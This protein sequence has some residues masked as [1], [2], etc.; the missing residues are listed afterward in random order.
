MNF[1]LNALV[2]KFSIISFATL[3]SGCAMPLP[4]QIASWAL[5][6]ISYVA[7]EKSVTDHGISIVARKD[8]ALLRVVQGNEICSANDS[9][10]IA[11]AETGNA[12]TADETTILSVGRGKTTPVA[13]PENKISSQLPGIPKPNYGNIQSKIAKNQRF[14]FLGSRVWSDRLD[15]DMYY[16]VGSFSNRD[17]AQSLINKHS[18]LGP[19]VLVSLL[20]GN[21]VYR[22]AVG[23]FKSFQRGDVKLSIKK[24]GI[25]NAWAMQIDHQK[26]K[27]SSSKEFF[28]TGKPVALVPEIMK[29]IKIRPSQKQTIDGGVAEIPI[30][31]NKLG[32][33][34][35]PSIGNQF[36]KT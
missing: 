10:S 23:P 2:F 26:W 36:T 8:C 3:L 12:D 21:K 33:N 15:A 7:T 14:L 19:A 5:D 13:V 25:I 24:S 1:R 28:N 18:D 31:K 35:G 30:L 32:M 20:N 22:V 11:V 4:Y 9:G 17:Y 16:V 6:G 34:W 29:L 27:T